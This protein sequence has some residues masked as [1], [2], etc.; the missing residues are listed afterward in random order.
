[1]LHNINYVIRK[2]AIKP[3]G[4]M[5]H[6]PI[7]YGAFIA[8]I[9]MKLGVFIT[10]TCICKAYTM[11][12]SRFVAYAWHMCFIA[13]EAL[14]IPSFISISAM[15]LKG[16]IAMWVMKPPNFILMP[17]MNHKGFLSYALHLCFIVI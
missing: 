4:F 15:K 10:H 8:H 2:H 7:K 13:I 9:P 17:S 11:K 12:P 5:A 1:M 14:K 16:F 3:E 6:F